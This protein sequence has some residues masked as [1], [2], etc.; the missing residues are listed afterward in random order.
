MDRHHVRCLTS[1]SSFRT[2]LWES[3]RIED[4][5]HHPTDVLAGSTIGI[6][7]AFTAY[8]IYYPKYVLPAPSTSILIEDTT[9][10][11]KSSLIS[12]MDTPNLV[13]HP[14]SPIALPI[15]DESNIV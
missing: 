3:R 13:Y 5:M 6:L 14:S 12:T 7:S 9:S 2:N 11:F 10:P 4:N 8:L 1:S 15:D